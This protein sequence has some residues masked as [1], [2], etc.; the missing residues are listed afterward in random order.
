MQCINCLSRDAKVP[1][2]ASVWERLFTPLLVPFYCNRC[3][4]R[5]YLPS[6][7]VLSRRFFS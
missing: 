4:T 5:F 7:V 6:L 2:K 1:A 3:M